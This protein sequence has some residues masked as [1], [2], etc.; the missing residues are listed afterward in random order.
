MERIVFRGLADGDS[1]YYRGEAVRVRVAFTRHIAVETSGG[2]PYVELTVGAAT[3]R[4]ELVAWK[5]NRM[6]FRYVVQA[7]D[8]DGDGVSVPANGLKL[9]GAAV[10]AK[11]DA[12][13]A[14]DVTHGVAE[15]GLSRK[16]DGSQYRPPGPTLS[17]EGASVAEGGAGAETDLG[18]A[19]RLVPAA[20]SRVTVDYADAGSG[21]ATSGV[22]YAAIEG[23]TLTFEP[24]DTLQTA[25]VKVRGDDAV[26]GDETVVLSLSGA[27]GAELATSTV[28]GTIVDDDEAAPPGPTVERIVFRGLAAGDSTYYRG[29]AV[30]VRVAFTRHIAVETS[31]GEPHVELTVGAATRRAELVAWKLNRMDFRYV[32]QAGDFDGDGV[33]VPANGLKLN[34]AAVTAKDDASVDADVAHGVAEGGASRKVDGS[35]Y[36]PQG[37]TLSGEGASVAEGGAGAETDLGFAVRLAPAAASRVT[38]DYADAGSGT[39]TSGVDYAAIEGGTL[40]FEPGDTLQTAWVKVRGDDAV[41]GDETVVLSLSG[42]TG[43]E[44]ATSTVTGTIVD[45]DEAAPPGPTVERIVFLGLAAGDSTYYRGEAVRVRVAFTRH[46]AVETSGGEPHVELTVG[47][48]TRRA[49]LVAWKLNRMDFRYVVQAGDFD[50]DGVSVPA[51]GLK[52]NGA[53][54]TAK[55]D[56]SV[57]ADVAHGVAEGGASRKVDGSQY[58]P[59]GPTLSGEGASVAEGG[60]GAETDLG[61]AVRLAPAAASRVT[62]DYADAGSGTATSGVDYAAI[63]GGTLTFEPGD[64]LQTAWVKVRGDDAVEGDETVVLSL[65]G[66]TGAE[67]ATSTVTGT[68]V[69]DD[70]AAPPG[71]TVE[72]IVFLG[73]AAGDSTYYRGEAVRVRVAFT[74]HIAV[75]TSG[76]EP[77]VELTVGAATRRAELVAWK[78]NRMD[79]RYVVQADDFDGDGVSVPA[80]GLKLNGAAVTAKDDASVDADV[81]HGV[82]EGGASRKVDGSQYRPQGP[83]LSGEGASVAEGGAGAETDLG[84]AV[85]LAPAAASRVTVDYADAGSGTATSGVDYA[86][87]EGGTL[88]FEPGDTLQ[89][90]WVKVRGDDAVEGDETV[91]LS[92]SGATGAELATSTVTG[93]IV[94]DDEAAPPGPTVE[95]IVFLGLAAGDSTY[96][97]GEAVRVR[98]A[99]TRHIAVETSGGEPH[100]EL[101]VGAA[102]RRAELVAWKLNRMDFRYVVQADDFDGDGVSVPANGLKLNGAA[103]TAKDAAS[104]D[105][106]VAHGVA[107]GGA[108]RKVDGSQYRPQG[109]TLSGEGASVAEGGAGAETDLGFAVRLAPPAASRVTVDYADAGSGT[110]T[111]GVDYAAIGGGTL[112]F[113]PGD[114]LQ[115]VWVKVRGDDAVEDDETVVL[116]LSGAAGAE[117]ATSTVTGTIV[118][119]DGPEP[120]GPTVERIVFRGLAAGDSTY[121]RGEAV[122]VR[123]AFTRHIAMEM[124][125]GKPHVELTVGAATRRAELVAWKLNRMDFRYVVQAGDLDGD[126]VSVPANGLKLNG[127]TVKARNGPALDANPAHGAAE[128]GASRK[129]DGSGHRPQGPTLS[130]GGSSA[131]EGGSDTE[132]AL[133]FAVWLGP[134]AASRVT[135]AYADA[136]SGTATAGVDYAEIE[137]DTL[138]FEP[139]ETLKTVSVTVRGDDEVEDDET[140]V[141]SLSGATNAEL[142]SRRV[143]GT[144]VDDD[145]SRPTVSIDSATIRE[146]GP[147]EAVALSFTVSLR[148]PS[149]RQVTVRYADA[150]TGTATPGGDYD[151]VTP[152]TV[153]FAAGDTAQTVEVTV[154]G[155]ALDEPVETIVLALARPVNADLP[156]GGARGVGTI[157]DDDDAP[158]ISGDSPS[159]EEGN[160]EG[161][162]LRFTLALDRPSGRGLALYYA[163][164]GTGT[165]TSG[166]DYEEVVPDTL[167]FEPGETTKS[168]DVMVVGDTLQELDETVVLRLSAADSSLLAVS[169]ALI[170]GTIVDDDGE[171]LAPSF[172][173]AVVPAQRWVRACEIRAV[174]LPAA[175]GGDA[176]LAYGLAPALPLGLAFDAGRRTIAGTP[177]REQP[178]TTYRYTA[179]DADGDSATLSFTAQVELL[180]CGLEEADG[181]DADGDPEAVDA[182]SSET[183]SIGDAGDFDA[184]Q[185]ALSEDATAVSMH[186]EDDAEGGLATGPV[187]G[188]QSSALTVQRFNF[189][190]LAAGDSTYYRG[191][192]VRVR[193]FFTQHVTVNT[194]GGKPY[195]DLTVGSTTRRAAYNSSRQ[196]YL[197]FSYRVQADDFDGDGVSV[198]ANGLKL[199][200][201]TVTARSNPAVVAD[202]AHGV[203]EGGLSRKVDGSQFRPPGLAVERIDFRSAPG[204]DSTYYRDEI[205]RVRVFFTEQIAVDASGGLPSVDLTV[206]AETRRAVMGSRSWNQ[207]RLELRYVVQA[208]DFDGDGVSVQAN[209]LSLNGAVV[210]AQGDASVLAETGH[211]AVE[212]GASQKVDGS[213]YRPQ[214]PTLS[215]GGT[216]VVEGDSGAETDLE[217]AVRL[218]PAA[219]SRVTVDYADAGSGTATSG[220]DYAAIEGGTLTFEPG[221]TLQTVWVKVR[222]DDEVE[223]DETVVLSLSGATGA[224]LATSTVRGTIVNDDEAAPALTVQ[225]FNFRGLGAADSTYY[226]NEV[227]R[228]RVFFTEHV[229]VDTSGGEPYLDLTVG[230]TT[231]R[232]AYNSSRQNYLGFSYRVQA[233][234]F[235]GDGVSVPANG[236][237][238]NGA[239]VTARS[240]PAVVADPAH[241]VAEGGLSRKVDGSQFRPQGPTLS[242]GGT[243][244]VEGD[245]GAET[246][247]EFAVRLVPAAASRVTVEYA[248]AGSGTAT[249]GV[250][251]AAIG[252]GT[253][254][255]EPG[256]TLQ[257]VWVKVRGDDEVE[258][259]ETVVLSLSGAA[260]AELATSTVR[261]TIVDDDEA[262]PALTVQRFNFRGLGASD[263]TYYLNEVVRVRVFFTEHVTVDTSGGEPYLDLTVGATT[264]R[265]DYGSSRQN[266]LDFRYRVQADDFDGDGV[267]VPANGL[268]LNGATVTARNNPSVVADP[269]HGVAEGGL[270]RKVDGSQL[271]PQGPTL[272][273]GGT[274]VVEGDSGAETDLEFAVRLAP[275]AASRVT[276]EYA[277]AGS[278]TATSGVD[279]AAIGSGTLTFEPGDTL[280]TVWVKVRGDD[281]VEDDETVV[282]S[283]SGA[284]GAELATSTVRGTIVNDDEAAPA[285]T[286]QRFNFRGLGA[287]D[288]TYY[289]NEVVRVRVFF[290]EH[291][292]VDTSGGEPYLDLTVGAT[293]R[294]ADYGSSRQNY[295]DFS[296]R[297]QADDFDGDGVSV[298]ANGLKLNGA[299]VTARNN[300]SVV[301]DPGHGVAEGGLSRKVDGSQLRPQGPTLSA[302]GTSVVEGDSGA[303]TDLEFAVRLAPPAASRVTVEYADAGSGTAT[304]GVD[305]AA[306]EGGTLTFEPGETLKTVWVKVRGDDEVEDDET[307]VLSLSGAAGAELATSTV[308]GTIVDD[309][310]AAPALTVQRF[311]FRGLGASD[312]TYYL[313]EVVRVRVFFTE[314]VTVD[315]SGGEP[316]LDLTVGSTTR[317]AAYNSSRQN[318]LGFSYRVQADDFDGDGVSVPANGLKLNGATVTARSNPAVV[319]DPAHGVAEGGLSRKVDGSQLRPQGPTLSAGGTS[320]V[321]G[322]SGAETDLEFAV[323]LA[324]AAASRVTVDYADA[325]SGTATSGVDYAAIEGG[326]LTFEPGETLKTVW[327]KVRGDDEVEDDETV[328]LSLSGAAGAELATSTV[329]GTIVDDDEAAPALTVQRFNFRGLGASDSTYYLNEVVRVRVFF[330]EHVTVDTSG[331]EPYLDLTVGATTRRADYGSSRQ[332]YLDFR[333]RVQADD[334]DGDGVSVPANGLKLNGATVTARNNPSVVADP[335]HGV[336]EGGLSRKVDGSQLRP[337]GP[338]LSAGGTSVVEGD[339]GAETDLEFAVRLA[340]A[341]ASRV[342]VDYADAGSGTATSGVDYAAIEGGTLTFEPGDT[343]QTMQVTVRGDDEVEGDETVVLSLSGA[344]GAELATSTVRGTIVDDDGPEPRGPTVERIVFRGLAAGDSTYYRDEVVRVRVRFSRHVTVATTAGEPHLDLT[345]GATTR[346]ADFGSSRQNYL[347]FRYRVQAGDFDGDGV[348]VPANGLKLNGATV[349]ARNGPALD[350]NPAHGAAEGGASRKV[351][352]SGHRPQGPTLSAGG[353][354]AA[355][356]GSDTETA[357]EFAVWLGPPAASRV[358]VAYADAG[359]GTATA[360]V[361]YAEI[362]ADTLTF[363]PGETLKTVSVTVRGDDEVEDDETVVLSLSGATNA[364]LASRR[365]TGTIVDDDGSRPTVSIDSATIREPGPGEAVA[366]SFTVSLRAPSARQVTVRYADAGTGTATP[367]G[368]YDAVTPGTVV[369][370]A[371]DT[372]QTVEVTVR[373]DALDEPVETIVLALAR[374]VNADLPN[375]GA[376]GVGTIVDDDDAP[377]ISGDSPSVEEGNGEGRRLRFTLALDRP[378]GRGLALYYA[379]AGTGTAT[380]G[381]DYEEVVPDT[382]FFEPGETTKSIDVMVVGDTLQELDETVVL[383][384]SAADSSLLAVSTALIAGTI[385]D[386]DGEDLAPSFGDAVVPAQRWVRACEIRAVQLPA[387]EGGD[388]PLAYGLAPALPLGLAFDAGRRTIAGT[389]ER[390][391]PITTYRYTATDADGDSATLSFTAQVELLECGLEADGLDADGEPEAVDAASSETPSIGDAGDFDAEREALSEDATAVSDSGLPLGP[392]AVAQSATPSMQRI[393]FLGLAAGDSTYYRGEAVRVRMAFTHHIAVDTAGGKPYVDLTVGTATRRADLVAW[394]LNRLDFRY[395]VQATDFDGDGV[396]VPANG[397]K[398]NGATITAKNDTSVNA[399]IAHDSAAGGASR[400]VDGSKYRPPSVRS[401]TFSNSPASGDTYGYGEKIEATVAFDR[402]VLV[403]TTG[404]TPS[405][406]L[407]IG[408]H[409]RQATLIRAGRRT[410]LIFSY[411]VQ[412]GDLAPAGASIA[413]NAVRLNGGTITHDADSATHAI[414]A[415]E[416]VAAD[417]TRRVDGRRGRPPKVGEIAFGAPAPTDSVYYRGDSIRVRVAFDDSVAVDTT[418][419]KPQVALTVGTATRQAAFSAHAGK[420]LDF[421]YVVQA[422]DRDSDGVSIA[423]NALALNGATIRGTGAAAARNADVT[424]PPVAASAART[425]DGSKVGAPKVSSVA[426]AGLPPDGDT[427]HYDDEVRVQVVFDGRVAVDTVGGEPQL[428]LSMGTRRRQAVFAPSASTGTTLVFAYRVQSADVDSDGASIAANALALNGGSIKAEAD[429]TTAALVTHD[430]LAADPARKVD[431]RPRITSLEFYDPPSSVPPSAGVYGFGE[432]IRILARYDQKLILDHRAWVS[433]EVGTDTVQVRSSWRL[434]M[435]DRALLFTYVVGRGAMDSDGVRVPKGVLSLNGGMLKADSDGVTRARLDHGGLPADSSRRVNGSVTPTPRP[436]V[437]LTD[438]PPASGNT[439]TWNERI[440]ASVYFNVDVLVTGRP[441][442]TMNVGTGTRQLVADEYGG[443]GPLTFEYVVQ[444]ADMDADGISFPANALSL[445]SGATI[446]SATDTSIHAVLSHDSVPAD[447]QR[448]VDGQSVQ[449]PKVL[450][451][452][453]GPPPSHDNTYTRGETFFTSMV[454]DRDVAVDTTGGRPRVALEIGDSTRYATYWRSPRGRPQELQFVYVVQAGDRDADGVSIKAN[455]LSANGG[456]ITLLGDTTPAVLSHVGLFPTGHKVDGGRVGAPHARWAAFNAPVK[457][458]TYLRGERIEVTISFDRVASV[459]TVGGRPRIALQVGDSTRYATYL[460]PSRAQA[461]IELGYVVR[462]GDRDA[463][464]L[465]IGANALELNGGTITAPGDTTP[466]VLTRATVPTSAAHKVDGSRAGVAEV[467]WLAVG[468]PPSRDS[469]YTRGEVLYA[470]VHFN[471]AVAVDTTGGRPRI[472]I[473]I[474]DSTRYATYSHQFTNTPARQVFKY[475]VQASDRDTDGLSVAADALELNGGSITAPDDTVSADLS[476]APVAADSAFKVDGGRTGVPHVRWMWFNAPASGDTYLRGEHVGV[477][478]AFDR[479][480]SVDTVGGRPRI[481][482]QVGDSTRHATYLGAPGAR[483]NYG[484]TYVVQTGDRDA[485]GLSIAANALELNGGSITAPGDTAAAVLTHDSVPTSA[486]HKVDGSRAAG[487]VAAEENRAPEVVSEIAP[488]TMEVASP[489]AVVDLSAHFRDPDGDE[490]RYFAAS[491]TPRSVRVDEAGGVLTIHAAAVG[492]STV[493][494]RAV[495]PEG[496]EAEQSF[497]V[498]VE[499]SRADRARILKRSLAAFGRSVGTETVE[500]IGGRLGAA[501]DPTAM[502]AMGAAHLQVGGRSLS[503][504]GAAERCDL[505]ELARQAAGLL[506]VRPS[507][508]AGSLASALRAAAKGGHDAGALRGLADAFGRSAQIGAQDGFGAG[509]FG[510]TGDLGTGS[511]GAQG[512]LGTAGSLG[513][514]SFGA[515]GGRASGLGVPGAGGRGDR[516]RWGRLVA[517]DPVTRDELLTRSSF[518]F[519]PGAGAGGGAQAAPGGWTFWGRA[520]AGGFEGRPEDDLALDGTVRSA[521]LGADYRFGAGPLV[522]LALSRTTS[523]IG[524]ES[525]IN[526]TGTVDARLTSLYPYAQWS[527]RAG[528]SVWGL[529]GAGRGTAALS[530]DA[531]RRRYET[532]MGMAMTAAGVRQR[533]TGVLAVKADA[534]EVRTDAD[535]A[536]GLAGVVANVRRLRVASEVVGRWG[537]SGGS[538]IASQVEVGARFDGGDAETGAGAEAGAGIGYVHEG[539]GLSVDA[540]GRALVA[541]QASSFREWGASV[542]VRLRP[543]GE[544]GGLSFALEPSWGNAASGVATLW[545]EGAAA[546]APGVPLGGSLSPAQAGGVPLASERASASRLHMEV[547]YAI[548]LADGGRVAPFG[549]WAVEGGSGRRLNVGVRLSV[550]EAA[551]LDLFGEE[552]SGGA[553]PADRRLGLQGAVRFK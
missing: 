324:P 5:L 119:D 316:Y 14:A 86:A 29:E 102:T 272:S 306:I 497:L 337:Q 189:R 32:V 82:A 157:V 412:A 414:L 239:T 477:T 341:A 129:V 66:A 506:G 37:P 49:E 253:L 461:H 140:V 214:G 177:E 271:R 299:T 394:K 41:E 180:E 318:Y 293:T 114:T 106:D 354:S 185:E 429:S 473:E 476:H 23:G 223:D 262:A 110:A 282:L 158:T 247:L 542:A 190:G 244:V 291:V 95:R 125:G 228:V 275:P 390:E 53:A 58:R 132:T 527:P 17:G 539:I 426:F 470:S 198:P 290:T 111:S 449:A 434:R 345:V 535:E 188:A 357:L 213:Q 329:R 482:L 43:A 250:D 453:I 507:H 200:G 192:V 62:V 450:R 366:L 166:A 187:V 18:F 410:R 24:G 485:D 257:T 215:A 407:T 435:G 334:F 385:V 312:S 83:T 126:G 391:Q 465:S 227:V 525:G 238:L 78:L 174:Q 304:S 480:T 217:F 327:V 265:A 353:S 165:A 94:D 508:G 278:G 109:P 528:L 401:A 344:T 19:V 220:V 409:T 72:R 531:T 236:L 323:R 303:E 142:A 179:T 4:A 6:D 424:H 161:R 474:G 44:L 225:R 384:L 193:V 475:V 464:G 543:S 163:D 92:L 45:D 446:R 116:S 383:R 11:D 452:F 381:A 10:T 516:P 151:A 456:S 218:A 547:D 447:P 26:E 339:S 39:A 50:G 296:Y 51:N 60:A 305:Y 413:A 518:R 276:V 205:V 274:S 118:D 21:T 15:G 139:G 491:A 551:T 364:E 134:P 42:A 64:T 100:V 209:S 292:T 503:C 263:S 369:F 175:E 444:A 372:A 398:L 421:V 425:V 496:A 530:E 36:R 362:E 251:Y 300:P 314:H 259:D 445:P 170:A 335:G 361:D 56:A 162:R 328:V 246:D 343:L 8:L 153:V 12:S 494:V 442:L 347:D 411:T 199:N 338:T 88:T 457:G 16:V 478:V 423:T 526:G 368:D 498:T 333:Y 330:T 320:V 260:G 536:E 395:T 74:R 537:L 28:T 389:P 203:A 402:R 104:V 268:K 466:A 315:T 248:D 103:V 249:S 204:G 145:G 540:R 178:I 280:K 386:D 295:L 308:R 71:P 267:S 54:V 393:V 504:V 483:T 27:T 113:E 403:S 38:V 529:V 492:Q 351:D 326:T 46:I 400:K 68:I 481:A 229:T 439:Y 264:R 169:T 147:G 451:T 432:R 488:K 319:A 167:F 2:K 380:S 91:V 514:G 382:L 417:T 471:R 283:L 294:R 254:T 284:T 322:D 349:T 350:A 212:G 487:D 101:T 222:G 405:L 379:D 298:P 455:G 363:E 440:E 75:E 459:D 428:A 420:A 130:A 150:G 448:K 509:S 98:V 208:G 137:A 441:R 160:G 57:D 342:T 237:K 81:A 154:R 7:G 288:S 331:G 309:D 534:F 468:P 243:S 553:K 285:L 310:E 252:S 80:N 201:A 121:Y 59:Q 443:R 115:T 484:F 235:D 495:D 131:T 404:G 61:F 524:F 463:D 40:T 30:R 224:E 365:V 138:T 216:S 486:A 307:V 352:G 431:G 69:D 493:T 99:F 436:V 124:S 256:D 544:A 512:G 279:Y 533:L 148:A 65:S 489:P 233:D 176:P 93:T 159:V 416:A 87:I 168:I 437:T 52:L 427:Y 510:A 186:Q 122:R 370:A 355:E 184:E 136:G 149:A 211:G 194:S 373:G 108:S 230:S 206:G 521:Y 155:D 356:G 255:F 245:S 191:E 47:A 221:D 172:G 202:P 25:W 97:R 406:D 207:N 232:A 3:R 22:D 502:G 396:S 336:A 79:F 387:A 549:R 127:A 76:G 515:T 348:S 195:L 85:R 146:P 269:G 462:A 422:T 467:Q 479:S 490:L 287:S 133:E 273:A 313:N 241:G 261:G 517:M 70:E 112:T 552:V 156:N 367:G 500:A 183:P 141:L 120:R 415:H 123:V 371:G 181:L 374:P 117:L 270:S 89:T 501:D 63:E 105:A 152:G 286:V 499:A 378:S 472:A 546:G 360:G 317:R 340:P 258:D 454:F 289:L 541:H 73:L 522:G 107:E 418:S 505:Q 13:L 332:N 519:S 358:T 240:N 1:T 538:S 545:R 375:G 35:Q 266:Y 196:N 321:E 438:D 77:H 532:G 9:N 297:V 513:A 346:R 96:Y 377:T 144:I 34:G 164:A 173:D 397:L 84:F 219:A 523:L 67:L 182:A 430:S 135:V 419:G 234:D 550:L 388:A 301:A 128:G 48:A 281:E 242:A 469:T 302:G 548:V 31:G 325:G 143:T 33:S 231:R 277:D 433:L 399:N 520:S 511:L 226:L 210:T 408:A 392:V 376:R 311:N 90:A 359:S 171:D 460:G 55:D 20:A 197:G 458:D